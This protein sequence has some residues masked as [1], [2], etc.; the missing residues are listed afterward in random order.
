MGEGFK[1]FKK[2][3]L[4]RGL[5]KCAICGVS[6]GLF[7]A[8]AAL[9]ACK[10]LGVSLDFWVYILIGIG[11]ALLCGGLT[12]ILFRPVDKKLAVELDNRYSLGEKVQTAVAFAGAT[13]SLVEIQ[14][15]DANR[16]LSEV[17]P[18]IEFKF[19][20]VWQYFVIGLLGI[21]VIVSALT[22]PSKIGEGQEGGSGVYEVPFV[23]EDYQIAAM[24]E[25]IANIEDSEL[26]DNLKATTSKYINQLL[27][28]LSLIEI[29][30]EK[31]TWVKATLK[32]MDTLFE[33][34]YTY[35]KLTNALATVGQMNIAKTLAK[36]AQM[37]RA[38]NLNDYS[39][40]RQF[41][42]EGV[43]I[44]QEQIAD[45]ITEYFKDL[46]N[47][48]D[49]DKKIG[50]TYASQIFVAAVSADV[51]KEDALYLILSNLPLEIVDWLDNGASSPQTKFFYEVS[52]ALAG[53]SYIQAMKTYITYTIANVFDAE[54]TIGP[55][56]VPTS[57][58]QSGG[59]GDDDDEGPTQGGYGDGSL[60]G[61]SD[62][63][64][65]NPNT[66]KYER[67]IDILSDYFAIVESMLREGDLSEER[68]SV[69]RSYFEIL[70]GGF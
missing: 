4:L 10:L 34:A 70:Y 46:N 59:D 33:T 60:Q 2:R 45:E 55:E 62:D 18:K 49:E 32:K 20:K 65:Y 41:L 69:I 57:S 38:G 28:N 36:G 21:G 47:V 27:A 5:L 35:K 22:V 54:F 9:L 31:D 37:H 12:F 11:G 56:F 30:S 1:K 24:D 51:N 3:A 61:G 50:L 29:E 68:I 14:R 67:F 66:G 58:A 13:G 8:G 52:E 23:L 42:E 43:K 48:D 39:G 17:K 44:V 15:E 25:L 53:Q 63:I 26:S 7:A 6:F 64:I 40:V 16:R 19:K